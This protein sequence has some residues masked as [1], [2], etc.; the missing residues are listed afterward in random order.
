MYYICAFILLNYTEKYNNQQYMYTVYAYMQIQDIYYMCIQSIIEMTK[1]AY[2]HHYQNKC[3]NT[4]IAVPDN[5]Q[6]N[7]KQHMT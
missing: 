2:K 7:I 5:Q 4:H 3:V 6:T 1:S